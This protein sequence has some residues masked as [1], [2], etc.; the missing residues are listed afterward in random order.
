[1]IDV[2]HQVLEFGVIGEALEPVG[3]SCGDVELAMVRLGQFKGGPATEGRRFRADIDNH[4]PDGTAGASDELGLG[5]G[6]CLPVHAA[7]HA[8]VEGPGGV[9]LGPSRV[10]AMFGELGLAPGADEP[11]AGVV[12][13]FETEDP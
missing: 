10:E 4:I 3:E 6:R 9:R 11:P 8:A 12:A 1:M 7:E 13:G 2:G 5:V